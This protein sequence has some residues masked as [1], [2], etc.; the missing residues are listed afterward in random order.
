MK[1]LLLV[2]AL[3]AFFLGSTPVLADSD[4]PHHFKGL[5]APDLTTAL[6][7]L[8]EYNNNLNKLVHK[9]KLEAEDLVEVHKL[10]YT[11]E[12]ALERIDIEVKDIADTLEKVH[13]AS[14]TM[15]PDTVQTEGQKYLDKSAIL[16]GGAK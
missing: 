12:N 16:T 13:I 7:N 6:A 14:E 11:L 9:D 3:S 10:T 2:T 1:K 15:Q 4:K 8:S 5:E